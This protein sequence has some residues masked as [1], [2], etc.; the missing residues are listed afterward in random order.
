VVIPNID[1]LFL[2]VFFTESETSF[3]LSIRRRVV[4]VINS[5]F[6]RLVTNVN[7]LQSG[8]R[9]GFTQTSFPIKENISRKKH[10]VVL[11]EVG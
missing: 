7:H 1:N 4:C 10:S 11:F 5:H 6:F 2:K 8:M 9:S 3:V